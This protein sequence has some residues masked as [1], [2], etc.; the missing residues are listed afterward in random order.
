MDWPTPNEA[1]TETWDSPEA[2]LLKAI[3]TCFSTL[4]SLPSMLISPDGGL[5]IRSS[6]T[7]EQI[8]SKV[9]FETLKKCLKPSASSLGTELPVSLKY[10]NILQ[11]LIHKVIM[12]FN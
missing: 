7:R 11:I 4:R 6:L 9:F 12:D 2:S 5:D 1:P 8:Y 3:A 10:R